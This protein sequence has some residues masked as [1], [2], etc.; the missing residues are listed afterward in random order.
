MTNLN[1][2]LTAAA[3][4]LMLPASLGAI[5][6]TPSSPSVNQTFDSMW[7]ASTQE[8]T[9]TMPEGWRVDRNLSGPHSIGAWTDASTTVM[10]TGGTSLASNAKNGTWNWGN[11][12]TPSDRAVG[13]L[14]TTVSNGTR[15]INVM[16]VIDNA[17]ATQLIS[18]LNVS[19]N[20]E[21]YR[22]GSNAAGFSV[23]MYYSTD[24]STWRSAGDDFRTYF[25]P[26]A[27]TQG[28]EVVPI[29]TT[30]VT[31]AD[32][33]THV[34]AG[35][36]VYLA[37]N[38]SVDTGS[39]PNTAQG[40]SIDDVNITATF[41]DDD[42]TW[43]EDTF[44]PSGIYLRGVGSWDAMADWEFNKVNETTYTLS[45][46]VISGTFKVADA[47][48][49][50]INYG[51]NGSSIAM[52]TPYQ[53]VLGTNDNI[54]CGGNTYA[55]KTITLTITSE[56]ATLLLESDKSTDGL[57]AVYVIGDN[58]GWDYMDATGQLAR[59]DE[60]G[61][62]KGRVSF[63]SSSD[64]YA[65]WR[66]YQRLGSIGPWG[67]ASDLTGDNTA[68]TLVA[69]A[70]GSV[71]TAAGT[72]DMTFDITTGQY[73]MTK[74]AAA[75]TDVALNPA[76]TILVPT[77]P[78][79]VKV[80]SLNNSLI[81]YND[82]DQMFNG[83]AAAMGNNAHWTKH[84]LLGKSLATHWDE[85][86]GLAEDG[87]PGAKMLVRSDAWSHIILQEQS[88]LP[89]TSI[90][91][92]RTN[93]TKWVQYIR[94]NCPN[95][96]AVII[97]P[98]NWAYSGD[99][100]NFTTFNNTFVANYMDVA[101]ELGVVV[102]PVVKAYQDV[103]DREGTSG[104]AAW[105]E[106]DRHPT[107][108]A[109]Y[110]AACMEYSLIYN[111]DATTITYAPSTVSAS[112]AQ[113]MREYASRA[114]AAAGNV[115]NHH[116]ATVQLS[117]VATDE[118]GI[119]S[120]AQD[121][122]YSV[123]KGGTVSENGLFTS[124][125]TRGTSTV[126]M[127]SGTFT[128]SATIT[129]A[130]AVTEKV[131][132]P[133]IIVNADNLTA[134]EDFNSMT[135]NGEDQL[136]QA[137]RIDRQTVAPRTVGTYAA[138]STTTMYAGGTS[139]AS[140]A[141]NGTWNFGATDDATDRALGG[142]TTGVT[143]GSRAINVYTHIKN[144]GAKN[145]VSPTL[146]YDIEKY[147][148]GAN[149]AG[150]TVKLYYS[151][152]GNAWTEAGEDFVTSFG[153]DAATQGYDNAPGETRHVEATL[154]FN[155]EAGVDFYLAWNISAT[156]GDNCA[157]A[158]ALA[159]DNFE[160]EGQVPAVP[161]YKYHIYADDQTGYAS[162]GAYIWGDSEVWG[163]WPGQAPIDVVTMSGITW[164][165]F[166]H[167]QDS[168]SYNLI[169]NNWNN[170]SQLPDVAIQGGQDYWFHLTPNGAQL[171][172]GIDEV[173]VETQASSKVRKLMENGQLVIIK[174]G[175]RYNIMGARLN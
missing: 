14:T 56:G 37:W 148:Q 72:Y 27:A 51:S 122:T 77:V 9:L 101:S 140:N 156:S 24:G 43:E 32:L 82:Q 163:S 58:N 147:R 73:A 112:D 1:K 141:K 142:I 65:H 104:I 26:D 49:G 110:M 153:K 33:H 139:L 155:I 60:D 71:S 131:E 62:F 100:D 151:Y 134:T 123:D 135:T 118:F 89:R 68:G 29:S 86:E 154:P 48:W 83:I 22:E 25:A 88:S 54:S 36:S 57:T 50:S 16:T 126:T 125:G 152:S 42:P 34:L 80:L 174:D 170:G 20:I 115:V 59:D 138:A 45:D 4:A 160:L 38:I 103:Y 150:F 52:D 173:E 40:L 55:C 23:Q 39:S 117:A 111:E 98:V 107:P 12:A 75:V 94:E 7:D 149:D 124:D 35:E 120:A 13:G 165:V 105:Y 129:V 146:S 95:P 30:A 41:V 79:Q 90:E 137:W 21:K 106:D 166:G 96:N 99:W 113:K 171:A 102:C 108:I 84:T 91:T 8:A 167:D 3:L 109:T 116:G 144:D 133:A 145:L 87:T 161:Q 64:G 143:G 132:Y 47:S 76:Q 61:L 81:Y 17:H 168:G 2:T 175:V 6:V 31:A 159:I 169:F 78:E 18:H 66:I 10:Y 44:T 85:G 119:E 46:K 136:P 11:S 15:G 114:M 127:T 28:A 53:L 121:V 63:T 97:L 93:V 172:T 162:L 158:M 69:D 5:E 130:D 74:V 157:A 92:F 70:T 164:K 67:A 19:Y 128:R